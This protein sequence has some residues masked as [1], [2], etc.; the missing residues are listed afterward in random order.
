MSEFTNF[1]NDTSIYLSLSEQLAQ[2]GDHIWLELLVIIFYIP[3][4]FIGTLLSAVSILIFYQKEFR[5]PMYSYLM[6]YS[7]NMLF[8]CIISIY[9][10]ITTPTQVI[11]FANT[12]AANWYVSYIYLPCINLNYFFTTILNI[13]MTL[14]RIALFVPKLKKLYSIN[15]YL[16]CAA[17]L[18]MCFIF[19]FPVFYFYK[20]NSTLLKLR[21]NVSF[22][23]VIFI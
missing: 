1:S 17:I 9:S 8:I 7:I 3:A 4:C 18:L 14:D 6:V 12:Y 23:F 13:V 5:L 15:H 10:A 11:S 2:H 22:R 20:P 21:D 16:V 19:G